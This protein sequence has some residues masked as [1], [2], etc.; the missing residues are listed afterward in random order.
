MLSGHAVEKR[1]RKRGAQY[2]AV[3]RASQAEGRARVKTCVEVRACEGDGEADTGGMTSLNE[4]PGWCGKTGSRCGMAG[5]Q[6]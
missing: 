2:V 1:H 5:R 3:R 4:V 6:S